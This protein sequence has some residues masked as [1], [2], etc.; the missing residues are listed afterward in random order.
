[1]SSSV[2]HWKKKRK[3]ESLNDRKLHIV[4]TAA[5]LILADLKSIETT[6]EEYISGFDLVDIATNLEYIPLS[7]RILL[8]TLLGN[9]KNTDVKTASLDQAITQSARPKVLLAPLQSGTMQAVTKG[10]HPGKSQIAFLPMIDLNPTDKSYVFTT[11]HFI[12]DLSQRYH[13]NPVITFDQPLW[14]K[15]RR[16]LASEPDDSPL[17]SIFLRLGGFHTEM[18][19]LGCFGHLMAGSGLEQ[20]IELIYASNTV[21]NIL[22]YKALA[23]AVRAHFLVYS[24]L[25]V[26]IAYRAL[27]IIIVEDDA[28]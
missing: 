3:K 18:S 24:A 4:K 23:R 13:L 26:L 1:M 14:L 2:C 15:S 25:H 7:L 17:Q 5:E 9:K 27:N 6:K 8:S 20:V 12:S 22:T 21:P 11:L 16:I 19:F 28:G 10:S